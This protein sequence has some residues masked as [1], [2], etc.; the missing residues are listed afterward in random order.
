MFNKKI[1]KIHPKHTHPRKKI[2]IKN[3]QKKQIKLKTKKFH[4][5]IL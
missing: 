2:K 3:K 4:L 1:N 5:F